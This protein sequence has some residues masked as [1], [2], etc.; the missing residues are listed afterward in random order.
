MNLSQTRGKAFEKTE[1][2]YRI[3]IDIV[4]NFFCLSRKKIKIY[5]IVTFLKNFCFF[6]GYPSI[7]S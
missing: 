5:T 1:E 4:F 3:S 2:N 7:F 6:F